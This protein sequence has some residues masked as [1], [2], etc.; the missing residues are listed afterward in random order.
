MD[1]SVEKLTKGG[2]AFQ[3]PQEKHSL[4]I[5]KCQLKL[6]A[7]IIEAGELDLVEK[8]KVA[9]ISF[10]ESVHDISK[11][12]LTHDDRKDIDTHRCSIDVIKL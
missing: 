7:L 12:F 4:I 9:I 6:K 8:K 11:G 2:K 3:S 1:F 10:V 5:T